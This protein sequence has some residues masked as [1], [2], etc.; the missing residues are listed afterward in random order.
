[1][2]KWVGTGFA[3]NRSQLS[4][5][6][7]I[8][9]RR[10]PGTIQR[11]DHFGDG[12]DRKGP[13]KRSRR[14]EPPSDPQFFPESVDILVRHNPTSMR[15]PVNP[16]VGQGLIQWTRLRCRRHRRSHTF[17]ENLRDHRAGSTI[18]GSRHLFRSIQ[19][20]VIDRQC[21][22]HE[23]NVPHQMHTRDIQRIVGAH[24]DHCT[25]NNQTITI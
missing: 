14:A 10:C 1:M 9:M 2:D 13:P 23:S 25:E 15:K 7:P 19:D 6:S 8:L 12:R 17:P 16:D 5:M 18:L 21:R 22:S 11:H 4:H 20:I 3:Q 24:T